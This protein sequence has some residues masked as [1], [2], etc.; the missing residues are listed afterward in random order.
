MLELV[1]VELTNFRSFANATF[2]P[3]GM[4][5]GMTAINGSN[6][7]GKSTITHGIVWA[8]YGITP[9]GVPVKALRRQ[10]S[11]GE[12]RAT[13]TFRHNG[14]TI[15]ISRALRGRNDS[16]IASITLNGIEETSV[17]TK[18]ATAWIINRL[19]LDAEAFLTAFVVRQKEL[20][21]LVKARPAERRKIIERLAGIERMSLA[22]ELARSNAKQAQRVLDAL[23]ETE[24]PDLAKAKYEK[25]ILDL[26]A[27]A[28]KVD[29]ARDNENLAEKEVIEAQ[30][31][32]TQGQTAINNSKSAEHKLQLSEQAVFGLKK[33]VEKLTLESSGFE[34]LEEVTLEADKARQARSDAELLVREVD[35]FIDKANADAERLSLAEEA[36]NALVEAINNY[37]SIEEE[38]NAEILTLPE[39]L[40]S[41]IVTLTEEI[42]ELSQNKGAVRGEWDRLTKAISNL[43][44]ASREHAECPTC[45]RVL[46]D[47]DSLLD[48]LQTSLDRV[49]KDG[50][51]LSSEI[52][53]K[54]SELASLSKIN[55][56]KTKL[57]NDRA[58]NEKALTSN[59][60]ALVKAKSEEA[61][62]AD[63]A[64]TSAEQAHEARNSAKV[65]SESL[66][67]LIALEKQAQAELRKIESAVKASEELPMVEVDLEHAI[68]AMGVAQA[69][70]DITQEILSNISLED[71]EE[72]MNSASSKLRIAL[73]EVAQAKADHNFMI[74]SLELARAALDAAEKSAVT[75]KKAISDL[76]KQSA[77]ATAMDEFRRDRLARLAPELS[78]VASDLILRMT[79]GKYTTVELDEDFTPILT[80]STGSER[81]VAWLSGGEES[82]VALALRVAIGEVLAGQS[83]GLLILDE[84]LT[85]Q[86]TLRRQATMGAIRALPR[87]IITINHVSESTDMVD[88]V[89]DVID[90]GEGSSTI[91]ES[92]PSNN[93]G[94]SISDELLTSV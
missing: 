18:T 7:S 26:E 63:I 38:L 71:L 20:D 68:R 82:T 87:Q 51:A 43:K 70:V 12:V 78:E 84:V 61:R 29:D 4:G 57:I 35:S 23:P 83:G 54:E 42:K 25:S 19:G 91:V 47:V 88:L 41:K 50:E 67:E 86:D 48:S 24:D 22:L 85:A 31:L 46:E 17:S 59:R 77:L 14:D 75:R 60:E 37:T 5:Q 27:T 36:S 69:E 13:V 94:S 55:N 56:R 79:D 21:N 28:K 65:A 66:P 72:S 76:E 93:L 53:V 1:N 45:L 39:D 11:E 89:A 92:S 90:D 52:K 64:E 30:T 6:G 58:G 9:D 49:Q 2:S 15:V 40:D 32:L 34:T 8:F 33:D 44:T 62:L 80:D 73:D 81:P 3:L 74:K 16:T 10:G